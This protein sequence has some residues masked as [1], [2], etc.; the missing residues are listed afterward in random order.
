MTPPDALLVTFRH[1]ARYH[2]TKHGLDAEDLLGEMCLI[3]AE[4][5]QSVRHRCGPLLEQT[6]AYIALW[7][8]R[9]GV[10]RLKRQWQADY[11]DEEMATDAPR[12]TGSFAEYVARIGH[13]WNIDVSDALAAIGT[14]EVCP[15]FEQYI[16]ELKPEEKRIAALLLSGLRRSHINR[17]KLAS[18]TKTHRIHRELIQ[19]LKAA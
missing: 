3:Y 15:A 2:A 18:P 4:K 1:H 10:K 14:D 12:A 11:L 5:A 6:P 9:Y 13:E 19:I 16:R 17:R 7:A 8:A